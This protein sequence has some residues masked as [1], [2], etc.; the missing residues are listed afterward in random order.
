MRPQ[1]T[2]Y[3]FQLTSH[4]PALNGTRQLTYWTYTCNRLTCCAH[5]A[6]VEP[7][8][9]GLCIN[10]PLVTSCSS[11][12]DM[13]MRPRHHPFNAR[14]VA[15]QSAHRWR[16]GV[17]PNMN[18]GYVAKG[19]A[20]VEGDTH[21][22]PL[23]FR[24]SLQTDTLNTH[25][26]RDAFCMVTPS[27]SGEEAMRRQGHC[28]LYKEPRAWRADICLLSGI[29][30]LILSAVLYSHQSSPYPLIVLLPHLNYLSR[31]WMFSS[32]PFAWSPLFK[33]FAYPDKHLRKLNAHLS[34]S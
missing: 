2:Q 11:A 6:F 28:L 1:V 8:V 26:I 19:E 14:P 12:S 4:F 29:K 18:A 27:L 17:T 20:S 15:L 31:K 33:A 23:K 3:S 30:P 7:E 32:F 9:K 10:P 34:E 25:Y 16:F 5:H 13:W 22:K 21:L 24:A